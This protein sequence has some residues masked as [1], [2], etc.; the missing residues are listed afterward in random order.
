MPALSSPYDN[1]FGGRPFFIGYIVCNLCHCISRITHFVA[2]MSNTLKGR[3]SKE[4]DVMGNKTKIDQILVTM[5]DPE[6]E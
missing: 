2:H 5:P 6:T 3:D 1:S 4:R